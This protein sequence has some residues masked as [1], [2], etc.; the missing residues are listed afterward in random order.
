[1]TPGLFRDVTFQHHPPSPNPV[2]SNPH[3]SCNTKLDHC[4]LLPVRKLD[5]EVLEKVLAHSSFL[6]HY[7][8]LPCERA[9]A[10]QLEGGEMHVE[11]SWQSALS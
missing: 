9:A 5:S 11:E 3:I 7:V 1:M 6:S 10:S 2:D 8:A 4:L